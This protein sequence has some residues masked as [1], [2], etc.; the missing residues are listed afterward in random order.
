MNK[1]LLALAVVLVPVQAGAAYYARICDLVTD[2]PK[3]PDPVKVIGWVTS[4]TPLTLSDSMGEIMVTGITARTGDLLLLE[5]NFRDGVLDVPAAP[6][7]ALLYSGASATELLYIP[8]G[9]FMMGN[10]GSEPNSYPEELPRHQV[11]L[12]GYWMGR[13]EVTRAEYRRFME[14]DGYSNPAFWTSEGWIW[15]TSGART[16]PRYWGASQNF[17]TGTFTQTDAHPVVGVTYHEAAAYCNWAGL[18]LPTEAQWEM[19]SRWDGSARVYPWGNVYDAEASNCWG[20]HGAAAGGYQKKQTA[21]VGSYPAGISPFGIYDTAGNVWEW[22][23]DWFSE[24]YYSTSPTIDPEGPT[25]GSQRAIRGGGF[26]CPP[27]PLRSASR[28][29]YGPAA[30]WNWGGFRVAR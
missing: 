27:D 13:C 20:D 25:T 26:L 11:T 5:G 1:L 30:Y 17:G 22:C 4:E 9:S 10:N 7:R 2:M 18:N 28:M 14:A 6:G 12:S 3:P 8:S 23:R 19:A 16:E 24:T 21:P 29:Y 15:R